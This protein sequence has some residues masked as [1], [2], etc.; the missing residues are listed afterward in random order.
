MARDLNA[1]P[2]ATMDEAL[3]KGGE[4]VMAAVR[5]DSGSPHGWAAVQRPSDGLWGV[6]GCYHTTHRNERGRK[7]HELRYVKA[8]IDDSCGHPKRYTGDEHAQL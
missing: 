5:E 8:G 1:G 7:R 6:R 2:W 4:V 3:D